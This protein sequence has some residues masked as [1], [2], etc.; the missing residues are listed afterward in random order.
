MQYFI[1]NKLVYRLNPISDI[2]EVLY[3][4]GWAVCLFSQYG[5]RAENTLE[6]EQKYDI[7][8]LLENLSLLCLYSREAVIKHLV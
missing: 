2:I 3:S 1:K 4:E 6:L 7:Q 8:S 5:L